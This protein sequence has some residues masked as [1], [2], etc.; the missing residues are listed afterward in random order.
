MS[1]C[2][3]VCV[4]VCDREAETNAHV[5]FCKHLQ[6]QKVYVQHKIRERGDVIFD[7]LSRGGSILL[8]G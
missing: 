3:C 6:D 8:A 7:A 2:L 5:M 1:V 4:S